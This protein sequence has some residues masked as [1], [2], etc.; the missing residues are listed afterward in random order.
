LNWNSPCLTRVARAIILVGSLATPEVQAADYFPLKQGNT[1]RYIQ[2]RVYNDSTVQSDTVYNEV[3]IIDEYIEN[4]D[5]YYVFNAWF[6][7]FNENQWTVQ[8][9][10]NTG[11]IINSNSNCLWIDTQMEPE[12]TL[13]TECEFPFAHFVSEI[14]TAAYFGLTRESKLYNQTTQ[15]VSS[16]SIQYQLVDG[17]GPIHVGKHDNLLTYSIISELIA[18]NIDGFGY[19]EFVSIDQTMQV[20]SSPTIL[21]VYPNPFNPQATISLSL[22][23]PIHVIVR[24]FDI[25]GH[26]LDK[27]MD[28]YL[29]PGDYEI[30]WNASRY[31]SGLYIVQVVSGRRISVEK[32]I[33][34][35]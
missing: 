20:P 27:I 28:N 9:D 30:I 7:E 14:D 33:L 12:D 29:I 6:Q 26:Q 15:H 10:V 35:K 3:T 2:Y 13:F 17:I 25:Q 5:S 4:D 8:F 24:I 11:E 19:G 21:S 34:A 31:S 16:Q 18:A 32:M 23:R 1:W 22:L